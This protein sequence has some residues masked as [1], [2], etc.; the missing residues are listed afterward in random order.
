MTQEEFLAE[1]AKGLEAAGIP[2]MVAGS[3]ARPQITM[4]VP[5]PA[6]AN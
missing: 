2:Y 6:T 1:V 4:I 3:I 5:T